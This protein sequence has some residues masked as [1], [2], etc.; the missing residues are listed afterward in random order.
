MLNKAANRASVARSTG[1]SAPTI[2]S[3]L[4]A[5]HSI[6][7]FTLRVSASCGMRSSSMTRRASRIGSSRCRNDATVSSTGVG[8]APP[9][10]ASCATCVV[11]AS[12]SPRRLTPVCLYRLKYRILSCRSIGFF[13][14][15]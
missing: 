12:I 8:N 2:S 9:L 7:R 4:R 1:F 3:T 15:V 6:T 13:G 5:Y 14:A 11:P 10:R